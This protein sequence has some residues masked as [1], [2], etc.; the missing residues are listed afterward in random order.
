MNLNFPFKTNNL[1]RTTITDEDEHIRQLVE[2]V[3][4]TQVG[5]RVNRPTFGTNINQLLFDL[6]NYEMI[7]SASFLIQGALQHWLGDLITVISVNIKNENS[8]LIISITYVKTE[9]IDNQKQVTIEFN[10]ST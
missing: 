4:F 9:L 7:N 6:N 2:Q 10:K 8:S 3:L 1:G 5:E